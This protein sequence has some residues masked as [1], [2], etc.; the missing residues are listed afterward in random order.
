[1]VS[2]ACAEEGED[3]V[4]VQ[5]KLKDE[6]KHGFAVAD[7]DFQEHFVSM[8]AYSHDGFSWAG[9]MQLASAV[10]PNKCR[11]SLSFTGRTLS[12]TLKKADPSETWRF[13]KGVVAEV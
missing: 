12:I 4:R 3:S 13:P 5:I 6:E 1:M 11:Y 2:C 9:Q 10:R 7:V 8:W